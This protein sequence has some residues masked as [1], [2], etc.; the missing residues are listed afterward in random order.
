[1]T[2]RLYPIRLLCAFLISLL[3]SVPLLAQVS[4]APVSG[5]VLDPRRDPLPRATV[6]LLDASGA[7]LTRTFTDSQGRF[8]FDVPCDESCSLSAELVG[9]R[10]VAVN[11]TPG[12]DTELQLLLA[13]VYE[14]VVVTATRTEAPTAQVGANTSIVGHEEIEGRQALP[15]ADLLRPLPAAT[16]TRTGGLGAITTLF[17]RGG[18]S[19]HNKVL[20]DGI[21]LNEPGGFFD[22]SN[23]TVENLDRIEVVRGPQ[24]AL[25]GSDAMASVVQLFTARGRSETRRPHLSLSA[26]GGN[27]DTWRARAGLNGEIDW[28][29]YSLSWGRLSTD[30]REPNSA[31]HD[32]SLSANLG[33]ALGEK[34][35]L[36]AIFRGELGR[37]GTPGQ[38]A[39]GRP[40]SDS[41]LRRRDAFAALS[42]HNQTASFWE[43]NL[44][45]TFAASRQVSRNLLEDPP[46]VPEFDG[47]VAP[48][49]FFDFPF[50]FLNLARRHQVS[51]QNDFRA[52][53]AGSRYGLHF[54]T[55]A[56]EWD[57]EDGS[58]GDRLFGGAPIEAGRDNLGWVVQH[59]AI[60][61]RLTLTN[62]MRVED[63]DSFGTAV[64]PRSSVAY[65]VRHGGESLGATKLK[66]N[67]G[68]GITEPSLQDSFSAGPFVVG[69]PELAPERVRSFDAGIEQRFW[70][71]RAKLEV[72]WFDNR[73]RD[74]IAFQ[75][76]SFVPFTGSFFN[77]E[78]SKAKGTEVVLE[79]A[80]AGACAAS[81]AT[82]GWT[83]RLRAAPIRSARS[84]RRAGRC[85]A[86]RGTRARCGSSG[87]GGG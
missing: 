30:N 79:L 64:V 23:F 14:Q 11:V 73:W 36:R 35:S 70:R 32:T 17:I 65:L 52:G 53:T 54:L 16:V 68:L 69:N 59:Q 51:Y 55:F 41:F 34:T 24:S 25:F 4:T 40:D 63:N 47:S 49:A 71:D 27:N 1:M 3:A 67:F 83:R 18:E 56:F 29:D 86:G 28:F 84:F 12:A 39:F 80:P 9:F 45:Y 81:E 19:D 44:R 26:E 57:R 43:Q 62:G 10:S 48:F 2:V 76:I 13:P 60:L 7:E 5:V 72:N 87:T 8:R 74:L 82:R 42:L 78:S 31:F 46:F 22:F 66:F 50:D 38:T 58:F 37:A 33:T 21:P 6:R 20:L 15:A 85:S 61:G 77:V 75:V